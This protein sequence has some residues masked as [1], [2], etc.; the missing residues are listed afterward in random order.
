MLRNVFVYKL[1]YSELS[2]PKSVRK[3]SGLLR[4]APQVPSICLT[5][6]FYRCNTVVLSPEARY[7]EPNLLP[8]RE[9]FSHKNSTRREKRISKLKK[10]I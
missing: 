9:K 1:Q 6:L 7:I 4:N 10:L 2:C 3:V 5:L 8:T